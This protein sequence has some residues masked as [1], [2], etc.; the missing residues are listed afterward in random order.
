MRRIVA[1]VAL[2]FGFLFVPTPVA[3]AA[4]FRSGDSLVIASGETVD[5]DLYLAGN[6]IRISGTVRGDVFA[7]GNTIIVDGRIEGSLSAAG[8]T[9]DISGTVDRSVRAAGNTVTLSSTVGRDFLAAATTIII[10]RNATVGNDAVVGGTTLTMDGTVGRDLRAGATNATVNGMVGRNAT[11]DGVS[12]LTIGSGARIT[13][14]L[15]YRSDRDATIQSGAT[16]GSVER[17]P[18]DPDDGP[19]PVNVGGRIIGTII[20]LVRTFFGIIALGLLWRWLF[21]AAADRVDDT[22]TGTPL[23]SLGIGCLALLVAPFSL[24]VLFVVGVVIGG[25]GIPV[26]L[27]LVMLAI[28]LLSGAIVAQSIGYWLLRMT[29]QQGGAT[30]QLLLGAVILAI[31]SIIPFVNVMTSLLV[32]TVGLGAVLV[33]LYRQQ[34]SVSLD[35]TESALY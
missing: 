9:I 10:N 6:T 3:H 4:D 31:L 15:Q 7:A 5:D 29:R 20:D 12:S 30:V 24:L 19:S 26:I 1:I 21:R 14:S 28:L 11:F 35:K 8:Q 18:L 34:Q 22:L 16:V 25:W 17:L 13:G 23:P 33:A 32:G 27:W 2:V